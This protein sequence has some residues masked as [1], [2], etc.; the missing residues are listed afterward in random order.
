MRKRFPLND[1]VTKLGVLIA[2]WTL[3]AGIA[4]AQTGEAEIMGSVTDASGATIPNAQ[5]TL[6]NAETGVART[7]T[8]PDGQYRFSPVSPGTYNIVVKAPNF[9]TANVTHLII[10]IGLHVTEDV[11]LTVGSTQQTVEVSGA[12]P[13]VDTSSQDVSGVIDQQQITTLPINTRQYLNLAL[14]MPGTSQDATRTFYNNF[15]WA[16][17]GIST[18]MV[19]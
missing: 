4:I 6:T 3:L 19:S 5:V 2:M 7:V 12:V 13:V 17:A 10:N 15:R 9:Q 8:A 14:L 18:R 16:A 11:A 1:V